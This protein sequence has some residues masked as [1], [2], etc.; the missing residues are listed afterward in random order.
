MN[1]EF[2]KLKRRINTLKLKLNNS[3]DI[4]E[5]DIEEIK[6]YVCKIKDNLSRYYI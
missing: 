5:K 3:M 1:T 4:E 2:K 6:E